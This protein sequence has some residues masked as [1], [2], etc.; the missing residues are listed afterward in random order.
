MI[1]NYCSDSDVTLDNPIASGLT[2]QVVQLRVDILK[3]EL[4]N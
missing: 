3:P 1:H 4:M 2:E